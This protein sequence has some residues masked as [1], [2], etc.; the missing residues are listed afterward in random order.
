MVKLVATVSLGTGPGA[1]GLN[2]QALVRSASPANEPGE[3]MSNTGIQTSLTG[4]A[5]F[6]LID[7]EV[8]PRQPPFGRKALL[9]R[10]CAAPGSSMVRQQ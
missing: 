5:K 1:N 9:A 3:T 10:Y 8:T 6:A 2:A 7:Q 4:F